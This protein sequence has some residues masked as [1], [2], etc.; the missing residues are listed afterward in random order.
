MERWWEGK[1][2]GR[3]QR[4]MW[5]SWRMEENCLSNTEKVEERGSMEGRGRDVSWPVL[6]DGA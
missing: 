5:E 3:E 4:D 6:W 2:N 1:G